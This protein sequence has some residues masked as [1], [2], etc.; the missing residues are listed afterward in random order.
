[1]IA[2]SLDAVIKSDYPLVVRNAADKLSK[3]DY[4]DVGT[5]L[6][7]LS[8]PE[9]DDLAGRCARITAGLDHPEDMD[10]MILLSGILSQ[11]E[12]NSLEDGDVPTRTANFLI[13]VSFE[14]LAR[15]GVI[16]FYREYATLANESLNP[17]VAQL[18]N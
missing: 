11:A 7:E 15:K 16:D 10:V 14:D 18:K 2:Y 9:L 17:N 13:L 3:H 1:M 5:F 12:G 6:Q 8:Q 4:Y